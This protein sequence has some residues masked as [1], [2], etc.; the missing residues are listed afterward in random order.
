M[1]KPNAAAR[2]LRFDCDVVTMGRSSDCHIPIDDRYLSRK[3]AEIAAERDAWVL[4]DAGSTNGTYLN[5]KRVTAPITL[6]PGDRVQLGS[7][8]VVFGDAAAEGILATSTF[9][10]PT[11]TDRGVLPPTD[12]VLDEREIP[13][14]SARS[15]VVSRLALELISDRPG[16]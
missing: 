7:A 9:S 3:H 10:G 1:H 11:V 5:G 13:E 2:A 12:F 16:S 4:R 15:Q 6:K 14:S 8:E